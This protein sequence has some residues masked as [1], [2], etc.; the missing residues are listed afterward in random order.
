MTVQEI[1]DRLGKLK[2]D[3]RAKSLKF[4]E[5]GHTAACDFYAGSANAYE[6]AEVTVKLF[7]RNLQEILPE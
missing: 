2:V 3:S 6:I 7:G 1:V 5:E 4:R